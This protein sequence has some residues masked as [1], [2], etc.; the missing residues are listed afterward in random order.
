MA[1]VLRNKKAGIAELKSGVQAGGSHT[2]HG[3]PAPRTALS[4]PWTRMLGSGREGP[5][6]RGRDGKGKSVGKWRARMHV[7][8]TQVLVPA[9]LSWSGEPC[10]T[11]AVGTQALVCLLLPPPCLPRDAANMNVFMGFSASAQIDFKH[12]RPSKT[13][14]QARTGPQVWFINFVHSCRKKSLTCWRLG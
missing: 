7:Y 8:A 2:G 12:F 14:L 3:S 10:S 11:P 6:K 4:G 1:S 5:R 9:T 13:H